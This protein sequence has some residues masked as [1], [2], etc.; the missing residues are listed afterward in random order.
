MVSIVDGFPSDSPVLV[1]G[2][3][4]RRHDRKYEGSRQ[5][6]SHLRQVQD[7][8]APRR[9]LRCVRG[10]SPQ[11]AA[12]MT[13]ESVSSREA[14]LRVWTVVFQRGLVPSLGKRLFLGTFEGVEVGSGDAPGGR[15]LC[16]IG[17]A[18]ASSAGA[19]LASLDS[20]RTRCFGTWCLGLFCSF[21]SFSR[22]VCPSSQ[23]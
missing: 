18:A 17:R 4:D 19:G 20:T 12:R 1:E 11:T 9:R 16:C 8:Q 2:V 15:S 10:S 22:S 6:P 7:R 21:W 5:R 13:T 14:K 23:R 3:G